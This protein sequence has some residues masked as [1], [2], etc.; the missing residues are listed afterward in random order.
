M[1]LG[2]DAVLREAVLALTARGHVLLEGAP[3]TAKTLL[4][5][6]LSQA[7]GLEFRRIQFT[8]DLMPSDITGVNLLTGQGGLHLP[9]RPALRR[10]GAGRRDQPRAGQDPGGAARGDAGA[11][12]DGGRHQPPAQCEL[13]GVRHPESDR[14]RRD[15]PAARGGARPLPDQEPARLS[16]RGG[17][18]GDP[19]TGAGW[20]RGRPSRRASASPQ[21]LDAAGLE[22]LAQCVPAGPGGAEPHRLHHGAGPGHPRR[23]GAH[24]RRVA[25]GQRRAAQARRRPRRCSTGGTTW[26]RTT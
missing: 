13:H 15:L 2:Q 17:G 3:G 10:P 11:A 23:A 25:A 24:P 18:A 14:V 26:S 20:L 19:A 1:V 16:R 21:V 4:V 5:R 6:A 12:R 9:A 8:P 22:A 7:L